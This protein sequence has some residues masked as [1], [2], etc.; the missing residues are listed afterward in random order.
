MMAVIGLHA[1]SKFWDW[2]KSLAPKFGAEGAVLE[3][4]AFLEILEVFK[5]V[6]V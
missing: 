2:D 1:P 6:R 4:F 5:F 3:F